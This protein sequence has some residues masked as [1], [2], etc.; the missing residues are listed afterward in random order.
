MKILYAALMLIGWLVGWAVLSSEAASTK[1][2]KSTR[3]SDTQVIVSCANGD[4]PRIREVSGSLV[5]TCAK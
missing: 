3:L 1:A 5:L 2:I 4:M